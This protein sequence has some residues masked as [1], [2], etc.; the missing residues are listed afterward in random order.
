MRTHKLL[1][2]PNDEKLL[3]YLDGET[4]RV[5]TNSIRSHLKA[6]WAC[7]SALADLEKQAEV[8]SRLLAADSTSDIDRGI[9]AKERFL[10]WRESF[11]KQHISSLRLLSWSLLRRSAQVFAHP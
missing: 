4:S 8:I 2:H 5:Q 9:A 1:A 11:E 3:A 6:C 7:R 10:R